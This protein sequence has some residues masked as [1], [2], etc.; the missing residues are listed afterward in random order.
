V[1]ELDSNP[2]PRFEIGRYAIVDSLEADPMTNVFRVNRGDGEWALKLFATRGSLEQ[3]K[4]R[5]ELSAFAGALS[6]CN[7]PALVPFIDVFAADANRVAVVMELVDGEPMQTAPKLSPPGFARVLHHLA[8]AL[9][10]AHDAG[11]V[12]GRL[13]PRNVLLDRS[14]RAH[15]RLINFSL[16]SQTTTSGPIAAHVAYSSPEQ[17]TGA[18]ASPASDVFSLGAIGYAALT[19]EAPFAGDTLAE[20]LHKHVAWRRPDLGNKDSSGFPSN[21][22]R[23]IEQ[24][25]EPEP[26]HRD[27]TMRD[28]ARELDRIA[29]MAA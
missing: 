15:P 21:L 24:M 26:G 17:M 4:L 27:L 19:G 18:S 16:R 6:D 10:T 28:A 2:S 29:S 1:S 11:L 23:L 14:A 7:H 13:S 8:E 25:L 9:A 20:C 3:E 22:C 5:E 12:H